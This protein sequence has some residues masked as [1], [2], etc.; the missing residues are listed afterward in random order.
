MSAFLSRNAVLLGA[1]L[2][3]AASNIAVGIMVPMVPPVLEQQGLSARLIG[4]NTSIG[5]FGVM[6]AGLSLP[7]LAQR[8]A[9][10]RMVL[11]AIAIMA[12]GC[13]LFAFTTPVWS[14]YAIRFLMGL[15]IAVLFTIS[16]TWI[17]TEAG[18]ARRA[19]VMGVYTSILTLTFGLGPFLVAWTGINSTLPWL[20]GAALLTAALLVVAGLQIT[21]SPRHDTPASLT[22]PWPRPL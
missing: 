13:V 18:D 12:V 2:S 3:I 22:M 17:T 1:L 21:E 15:G 4:L 6:L 16:E 19:R 20:M 11:A 10:K 5:Q 8:M 7:W 9:S 14:W